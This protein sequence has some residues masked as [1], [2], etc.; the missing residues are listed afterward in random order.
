[1]SGS[2]ATWYGAPLGYNKLAKIVGI[3]CA[4]A[5]QPTPAG[6]L[7]TFIAHS[8]RRTCLTNG[9][10]SGVVNGDTS[11][12][13]AGHTTKEG[14][15]S[16]LGIDSQEREDITAGA[17]YGRGAANMLAAARAPP[18]SAR[19]AVDSPAEEPAA[20]RPASVV[21]S[22]ASPLTGPPQPRAPF[23]GPLQ[24]GAAGPP[25]VAPLGG[26]GAI[27]PTQR[28]R[29]V[30]GSGIFDR[31]GICRGKSK[32]FGQLRFLNR[33]EFLVFFGCLGVGSGQAVACC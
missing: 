31:P 13:A 10:N 8:L 32:D 24:P 27:W 4:R 21:A 22:C 16:Y 19:S 30:Q 15:K 14:L 7:G 9:A 23:A 26:G 1:L 2:A 33:K 11:L 18:A 20:K 29:A 5:G 12:M 17:F 28:S 6:G 25:P 3:H